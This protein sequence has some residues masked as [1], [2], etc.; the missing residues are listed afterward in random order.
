MHEHEQ[1]KDIYGITIDF[2]TKFSIFRERERKRDENG[3]DD[4]GEGNLKNP[5]GIVELSSALSPTNY[6]V[7]HSPPPISLTRRILNQHHKP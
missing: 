2:P 1:G 5:W 3:D 6:I 4:D 7:L